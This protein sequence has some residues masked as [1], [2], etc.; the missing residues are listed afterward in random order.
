MRPSPD[1]D[2]LND[3]YWQGRLSDLIRRCQEIVGDLRRRLGDTHAEVALA[4]ERL[5]QSYSEACDYDTAISTN[6]EARSIYM[7]DLGEF[8]VDYARC[9]CNLAKLY[10]LTGRNDDAGQ[11]LGEARVVLDKCPRDESRDF[12]YTM[13]L[14]NSAQWHLQRGELEHAASL[15]RDAIEQRAIL[16]GNSHP[17]TAILLSHLSRVYRRQGSFVDAERALDDGMEIF[18][19]RG[20]TEDPN[21]AGMLLSLSEMRAETGQLE[22][23][24]DRCVEALAILRRVRP[25]GHYNIVKAQDHLSDIEQQLGTIGEL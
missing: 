9:M 18:R 22:S 13:Q 8:G 2:E 25:P 24:K 7:R 14:A 10:L 19:K 11:L 6:I 3:L 20:Q 23:A 16:L 17:Q 4:L 1:A 21:Y 15:L 5:A 12:A